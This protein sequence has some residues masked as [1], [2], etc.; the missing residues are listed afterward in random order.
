MHAIL[1]F[2]FKVLKWPV[3]LV[4]VMGLPGMAQACW[5]RILDSL[6][7]AYL[8]F[9]MGVGIMLLMWGLLLRKAKWAR[10]ITT[11]E[12]EALHAIIGFISFIPIRELKVNEDGSGHVIFT[13]P[14]NW[15]M[16]L[17]PYFIPLTLAIYAALVFAL[18]LDPFAQSVVLGAIFGLEWAGNLREIHPK[19]TD[20]SQAGWVFTV[21]FLPSAILLSYGSAITI[22]L[23]GGVGPGWAFAKAGMIGMWNDTLNG[24][25]AGI[26]LIKS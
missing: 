23:E 2:V 10:F 11:I 8:P 21:L 14:T 3:A 1:H 15:L 22:L 26:N 25:I 17:A 18:K 7:E 5:A 24:I 6:K 16:L 20:F 4:A 19:Q 9:W 13:P 12:H